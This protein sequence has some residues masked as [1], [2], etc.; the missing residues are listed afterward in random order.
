M[1]SYESWRAPKLKQELV[2]RG[3]VTSGRK[4]D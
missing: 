4:V 2:L 3:A 1:A